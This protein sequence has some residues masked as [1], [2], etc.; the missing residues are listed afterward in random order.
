MMRQVREMLQRGAHH[1][2]IVLRDDFVYREPISERAP[3]SRAGTGIPA[4]RI[5]PEEYRT[6]VLLALQRGPL[7]RK[8]LTNSVRAIFGFDRT[9]AR[10]DT[11]IAQ[12]IDSLLADGRLGEASTWICLRG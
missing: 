4:D 11:A 8:L 7:D 6:A 12:A 3:R 9:G 5:P 2:M 10:L 1:G